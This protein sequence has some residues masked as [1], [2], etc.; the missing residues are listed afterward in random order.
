MA[1]ANEESQ[2]Y[3]PPTRLSTHTMSQPAF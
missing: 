1:R 2:F 3:L